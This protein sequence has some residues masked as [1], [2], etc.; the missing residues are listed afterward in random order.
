MTEEEI[1]EA[2]EFIITDLKARVQ[3]IEQQEKVWRHEV[4]RFKRMQLCP[5]CVCK[6]YHERD[7]KCRTEYTE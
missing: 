6:N 2:L 5:V 3:Q 1:R 7:C 4:E